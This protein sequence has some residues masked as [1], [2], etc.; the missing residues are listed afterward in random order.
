MSPGNEK[1]NHTSMYEA[2]ASVV[3]NYENCH[4][5][6]TKPSGTNSGMEVERLDAV[7]V[8]I[9]ELDNECKNTQRTDCEA[10]QRI[11]VKSENEN[12][13]VMPYEIKCNMD[14]VQEETRTSSSENSQDTLNDEKSGLMVVEDVPLENTATKATEQD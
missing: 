12:G 13:H 7:N 14:K 10:I 4:W 8:E 1:R 11:S 2:T 6:A 3:G 5:S 9:I